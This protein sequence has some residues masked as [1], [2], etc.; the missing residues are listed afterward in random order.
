MDVNWTQRQER[1]LNLAA[2]AAWLYYIAGNTQ[3]EIAKKLNVS[4]QAAQRFVSLG[5]HREI[6][7]VPPRSSAGRIN[8]AGGGV[9]GAL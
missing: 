2:R 4:R 5:G 7:P 1:K 8:D 3:D 6:D 9:A